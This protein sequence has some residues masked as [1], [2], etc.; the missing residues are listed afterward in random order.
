VHIDNLAAEREIRKIGAIWIVMAPIGWLMAA[1]SSVKDD[2][3]YQIQLGVFS[4][5]AIAALVFGVAAIFR[6]AWARLGLVALSWFAALVFGG[7]GL[8]L[9][10]ASLWSPR[11]EM[12]LMG[13]SITLFGLPFAAMAVRLQRLGHTDEGLRKSRA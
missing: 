8:T 6:Q 9:V 13:V 7:P 1:I 11:W 5:A 3:F 4:V 2:T 12:A 10:G